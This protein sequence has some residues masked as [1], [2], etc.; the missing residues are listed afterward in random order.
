MVG[1]SGF[2]GSNSGQFKDFLEVGPK[3]V[4]RD[5]SR[6]KSGGKSRYGLKI[7]YKNMRGEVGPNVST[8]EGMEKIIVWN[9]PGEKGL[10]KVIE[11]FT[12]L[13][14]DVSMRPYLWFGDAPP[15]LPNEAQT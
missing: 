10:Q 6:P 1:T 4:K 5:L 15:V 8:S 12:K 2:D 11:A 3:L 14:I 7:G 13:G 9:I